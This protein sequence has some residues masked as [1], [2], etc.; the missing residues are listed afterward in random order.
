M[1]FQSNYS[2][3]RERRMIA[4]LG[5]IMLCAG[6]GSVVSGTPQPG[7]SAV[8]VSALR[9]GPFQTEPAAFELKE[10]L[11]EPRQVRL[12]EGRRLINYLVNPVDI[13]PELR[14]PG[15]PAVFADEY[16]VPTLQGLHES[17]RAVLADNYKFIAGAAANQRNGSVRTPREMTLAVFH[18]DSATESRRAARELHLISAGLGAGT[19]IQVRETADAFVTETDG[20]RR[21]TWFAHGPYAILVS[22]RIPTPSLE[23]LSRL[24]DGAINAQKRSL[25]AH[26][27]VPLDEVLDVPVDGENILRRA[28]DHDARDSVPYEGYGTE[29]S[30]TYGTY[31]PAGIR[32]FE[33]NPAE[34]AAVF[35]RAG[36]DLIGRRASTVYRTRDTAAAFL[37]QTYLA[38]KGKDD[39]ALDPPLGI[40]DAQCVRFDSTDGRDHNSMCAVVYGR[41]VAVVTAKS[42]GF[43]NFDG[44]LQERAAAQYIILQKC[45]LE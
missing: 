32:H 41:Y 31:R 28:M 9:T 20:T 43:A 7:T 12:V 36:V 34:A 10:G 6:C 22:A 13:D 33:R 1:R 5:A 8:D 37:L 4:L 18:F 39:T 29:Y 44:D 25:D 40:A 15:K 2:Y 21:D 11:D 30:D 24:S 45:G 23:E 3:R 16:G 26:K 38:S 27:Q 35:E 42:I 14:I 19:N 17:H